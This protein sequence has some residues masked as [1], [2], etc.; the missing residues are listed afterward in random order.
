MKHT[1]QT[2][3]MILL[4]TSFVIAIGKSYVGPGPALRF[5]FAALPWVL[6]GLGTAFICASFNQKRE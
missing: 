6:M 1:E 2:I 3:G 4:I 5:F